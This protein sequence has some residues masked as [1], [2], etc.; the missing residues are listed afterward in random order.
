M[1]Y[2]PRSSEPRRLTGDQLVSEQVEVMAFQKEDPAVIQ[3]A[4]N[5]Y[6]IFLRNDANHTVN[7]QSIVFD[8]ANVKK[9]DEVSVMVS[10]HYR[11]IGTDDLPYIP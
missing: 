9:D 10:I 5:D 11:L 1:S 4:V 7:I 6:L 2:L 3:Q 8:G